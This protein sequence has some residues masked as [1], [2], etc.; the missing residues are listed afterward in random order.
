MYAGVPTAEPSTVADDPLAE[1][2]AAALPSPEPS[3]GRPAG[4]LGQA[5]IDHQRLAVLAEHDVARLQVAVQHA[6]AVGVGDGVAHVHESPEELAEGERV[7]SAS[8]GP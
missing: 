7:E 3:P 8:V 1:P 6:A 5:P 4:Q 2:A